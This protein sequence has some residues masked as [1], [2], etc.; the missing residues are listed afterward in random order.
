MTSVTTEFCHHH[1]TQPTA[2]PEDRVT[3]GLQQLVSALQGG[4]P[5]RSSEQLH[6]METLQVTLTGWS[7]GTTS[8][9][10]KK[11]WSDLLPTPPAPRVVS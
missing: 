8:V 6:A 2:T 4:T 11:K 7:E 9:D 5:A 3:H 10:P 1:I